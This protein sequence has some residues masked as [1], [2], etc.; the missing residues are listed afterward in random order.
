MP[1]HL[2]LAFPE[3]LIEE[4]VIYRLGRDFDVVPTI[5]RANVDER[6]AWVT[7]RLEGED[8]AVEAAIAWLRE[9]GI[10]VNELEDG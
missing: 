9:Q 5:R 7:L 2:H 8:R 1:A 6:F 4:P 3:H 10:E